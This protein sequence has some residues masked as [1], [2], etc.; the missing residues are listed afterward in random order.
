MFLLCLT[1]CLSLSLSPSLSPSFS[2]FGLLCLLPATAFKDST[3]KSPAGRLYQVTPSFAG[4]VNEWTHFMTTIVKSLPGDASLCGYT[5]VKYLTIVSDESEKSVFEQRLDAVP[6]VD[7]H[8]KFFEIRTLQEVFALT[9]APD[10]IRSQATDPIQN[11]TKGKWKFQFLK[12]TFGCLAAAGLKYNGTTA[13]IGDVC[14][15]VDSEADLHQGTICEVAT[16]YMKHKTVF[17]VPEKRLEPGNKEMSHRSTTWVSDFSRIRAAQGSV[18]FLRS[19]LQ[20]I[21]TDYGQGLYFMAVYHWFWEVPLVHRFLRETMH[22]YDKATDLIFM[23]EVFYHW[24]Y[25]QRSQLGYNFVDL[26]EATKNAIGQPAL[27]TMGI[28]PFETICPGVDHLAQYQV[29]AVGTLM[30]SN[31]VLLGKCWSSSE[32]CELLKANYIHM[33][34]A[35]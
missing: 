20:D 30:T 33:C 19:A 26:W 21:S 23:E 16:A 18:D 24:L 3:V 2:L 22:K 5:S 35:R 10:Y 12:K 11:P 27:A 34:V 25:P 17:F 6:S 28:Q 31:G 14:F 1:R 4:H 15:A 9:E 32:Q 13:P 29:K 7:V 8:R